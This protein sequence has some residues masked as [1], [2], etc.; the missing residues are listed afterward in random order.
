MGAMPR[1]SP[2][3]PRFARTNLGVLLFLVAFT[4]FLVFLSSYYLIPA[5]RASLA[6]R[7]QGDK[8]GWHAIS[9]TSALLLS[10]LLL[11]L[12]AGL[13]LTFRIGRFFF[14]RKTEPRT[15]TKYVD[16]WAESGK[17]MATPPAED[18]EA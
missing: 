13:I 7:Q 16:V 11:I 1:P 15:R 2:R 10:V 4:G 17:R 12:V 5:A 9:A 6:A 14:P 3:R 18:E 8:L